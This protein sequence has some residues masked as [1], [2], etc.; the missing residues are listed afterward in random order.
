MIDLIGKITVATIQGLLALGGFGAL[1]YMFI[2]GKVAPEVYIPLV[3]LMIGFF[4]RGA[5]GG[6]GE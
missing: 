2:K 6:G 3:S 5:K 4:F 1:T